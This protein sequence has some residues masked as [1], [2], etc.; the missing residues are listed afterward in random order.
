MLLVA[1]AG[2]T[3][4]Q[5]QPLVPPEGARPMSAV[6]LHMIYRNKSWQWPQGA[7]LFQDTDR[8]FTAV[9]LAGDES[10][11][12]QGR[13]ILSNRGLLCMQ[14]DWHDATGVYPDR[15]CFR[16]VIFDRTIYQRK[17]PDGDWYVFKNAARVDTDEFYRLVSDD[18]VSTDFEL[19]S[20]SATGHPSSSGSDQ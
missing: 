17:E 3:A 14:A 8:R 16:H 1:I 13:W 9:A 5:E 11:W 6:E 18:L 15:T 19:L 7:G 10:S 2:P 20:T 12:A 4:A